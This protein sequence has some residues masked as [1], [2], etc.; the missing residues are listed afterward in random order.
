MNASLLTPLQVAKRWN[1]TTKTLS[2]WRYNG[3]GPRYSKVSRIITYWLPD[4][5]QFENSKRCRSTSEYHSNPSEFI[6]Q[7]DKSRKSTPAVLS[8]RTGR[9]GR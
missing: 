9:A 5:E 3:R 4:I 6:D 2:Q 1:I 7:A 8:Y